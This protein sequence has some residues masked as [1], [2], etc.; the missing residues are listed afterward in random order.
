MWQEL[1]IAETRDTREIRRG[2]AARLRAISADTDPEAFRRL[3]AA[4]ESALRFA[5]TNNQGVVRPTRLSN[6]VVPD[7]AHTGTNLSVAMKR[8]EAW[9]VSLRPER[10]D[11]HEQELASHLSTLR[12]RLAE[13]AYDQALVIYDRISAQGLLPLH[14]SPV[15][16]DELMTA[17]M[18]DGKIDPAMFLRLMQRLGWDSVSTAGQHLCPTRYAAIRRLEAERWYQQLLQSAAGKPEIKSARGKPLAV[19]LRNR[20]SRKATI[21]NARLLLGHRRIVPDVLRI[22][23]TSAEHLERLVAQT[24][25]YNSLLG[26]RIAVRRIAQAERMIAWERNSGGTLRFVLRLPIFAVAAATFIAGAASGFPLF[27]ILV[28]PLIWAARFA[29]SLM[30]R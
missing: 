3:R 5:H 28:V 22:S 23:I 24:K 6:R 30:F 27:F 8:D 4:Y 2:Y 18:R 26:N 12:A 29:S 7:V 21:R 16:A 1:G 10:A 25:A 14:R 19:M 11:N 13:R 15:L 17:V 20:A 9:T